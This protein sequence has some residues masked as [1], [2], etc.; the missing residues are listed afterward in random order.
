[1]YTRT[2]TWQ[3]AIIASQSE[4]E[5]TNIVTLDYPCIDIR[6]E[7]LGY[8]WK[9]NAS[10]ENLVVL[11]EGRYYCYYR[12]VGEESWNLFATVISER[13]GYN[14]TT[15]YENTFAELGLVLERTYEIKIIAADGEKFTNWGGALEGISSGDAFYEN[16]MMRAFKPSIIIQYEPI[17]VV[18]N[19][20]LGIDEQDI[21]VSDS[22]NI[23]EVFKG[24]TIII[25]MATAYDD[26]SVTEYDVVIK[27][28]SAEVNDT[29]SITE[30]VVMV[31]PNLNT[32]VFE[33]L[34]KILEAPMGHEPTINILPYPLSPPLD[35]T[36]IE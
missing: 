15:V 26:I 35:H 20:Q 22:V 2:D 16:L 30:D 29:I 12:E 8:G 18:E 11:Y 1:M 3:N 7:L 21:N 10:D 5:W 4:D 23:I 32:L 19:V 36:L 24:A 28:R 33:T 34:D 17:A 25:L 6:F 13:A 9:E 31:L 27:I 14:E